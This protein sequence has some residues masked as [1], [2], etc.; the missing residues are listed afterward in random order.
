MVRISLLLLY[1]ESSSGRRRCLDSI[2]TI[3]GT[4]VL[5]L[6]KVVDQYTLVDC[7]GS[8]WLRLLPHK[9]WCCLFNKKITKVH[10]FIHSPSLN[11]PIESCLFP[12]SSLLVGR[13]T[14]W[15]WL[16]WCSYLVFEVCLGL[17]KLKEKT[18]TRILLRSFVRVFSCP[19]LGDEWVQ[20]GLEF[21]LNGPPCVPPP[22]EDSLGRRWM[23]SMAKSGSLAVLVCFHPWQKG[24]TSAAW[25]L[26]PIRFNA[27][28]A[29][30]CSV[31][32]V[33]GGTLSPP[34][35]QR[36][37]LCVDAVRASGCWTAWLKKKCWE[38]RQ[39]PLN[40]P[41]VWLRPVLRRGLYIPLPN[42]NEKNRLFFSYVKE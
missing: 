26:W 25:L 24:V 11:S 36:T 31:K 32:V 20:T 40:I 37:A 41:F 7:C 6:Q 9:T 33:G 2:L 22:L 21:S 12:C 8:C 30:C 10:R 5:H 29:T 27:S 42:T 13:K 39:L 15:L 17:Q 35:G 38:K 3:Q 19:I 23:A 14:I 4:T 1:N 28:S 16:V 34:R 18:R